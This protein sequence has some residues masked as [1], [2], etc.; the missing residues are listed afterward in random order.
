MSTGMNYLFTFM[1]LLLLTNGITYGVI[2]STNWHD[3]GNLYD[4]CTFVELLYP[5]FLCSVLSGS[6][7]LAVSIT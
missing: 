3:L 6:A 1:L 5:A 7:I 2:I 4:S